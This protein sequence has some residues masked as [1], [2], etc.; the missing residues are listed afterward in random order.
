MST[1]GVMKVNN[2]GKK[3]KSY[4][5]IVKENISK[6]QNK[7]KSLLKQIQREQQEKTK[8]KTKEQPQS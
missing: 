6:D 3:F 1:P 2:F 5:S 8:P 4:A 7:M